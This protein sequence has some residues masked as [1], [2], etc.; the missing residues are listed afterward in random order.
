MDI[1]NSLKA[2]YLNIGCIR[3]PRMPLDPTF[4][5]FVRSPADCEGAMASGGGDQALGR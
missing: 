1:R 5:P 2:A 3:C 4:V